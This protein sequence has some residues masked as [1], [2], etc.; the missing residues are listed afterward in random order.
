V[1][2]AKLLREQADARADD[3]FLRFEGRSVSFG[4]IDRRA[5]Q[6]AGALSSAGV[7]PGDRV[8]VMLD[9]SVEFVEAWFGIAKLGAAIVPLNT[10]LKGEPLSYIAQHAEPKLRIVGGNHL[11]TFRSAGADPD[12][13]AVVVGGDEDAWTTLTSEMA[14]DTCGDPADGSI[15]SIIYT[16]GTTGMPK[17]VMLP[18]HSYLNTGRAYATQMLALASD[19]VLYTPL[20]LFHVNAQQLSVMG[21]LVSGRPLVL[22]RRFSAS[23]FF[24]ELRA[25]GCTVFNYIGAMIATL[26]KQPERPDDA[27]NPARLGLGAAAPADVWPSFERRF[28]VTLLEGYGLTETGTV[29]TVNRRHD[30]RVGSIGKPVD[31]CDV[32]VVAEDGTAAPTGE[33]GEVAVHFTEANSGML[34]YF[35]DPE[36]TAA[37]VRDGWFHTGDRGYVDEDGFFYFVD[38][39]KDCIRRRGENISSFEVE[40]QLARHEAVLEVAVVGV[41]SELSEEDVMACV[42]PRSEQSFDPVEFRQ[43]AAELLPAFQVPRY[44]KVLTELP[45][46]ETHRA[47]KYLL[48]AAAFEGELYDAVPSGR[49]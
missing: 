46:T 39:L 32:R 21:A 15:A 11:D 29:A 40:R 49:G 28:G 18:E 44:V 43:W 25:E 6:V 47:Q 45:R 48:R 2:I 5:N 13:A 26:W 31:W 38:R 23:G 3:E 10:A 12:G 33:P 34:G 1:S 9:N 20:P 37:V 19:D 7:G 22:A 42:V 14:D 8:L 35:H 30:V 27:D 17:G 16:S 36:A 24:D 41:P 4:E